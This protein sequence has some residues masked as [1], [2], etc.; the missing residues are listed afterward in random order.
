MAENP[1]IEKSDPTSRPEA[2]G[3]ASQRLLAL[4]HGF[5]FAKRCAGASN[6]EQLHLLLTNDITA[7]IEF[8]RAFLLSHVDEETRLVSVGNAPQVAEKTRFSEEATALGRA[9][10]G[11]DRGMLLPGRA[12]EATLAR[13]GLS[14][15]AVQGLRTYL[16]YSECDSLFVLPLTVGAKPIYHLVLEFFKG[17][18]PG[19]T[20]LLVLLSAAPLLASALGQKWI[21][22]RSPVVKELLEPDAIE[23]SRAATARRRRTWLG[24]ASVVLLGLALFPIPVR[25]GGEALI[26]T[27]TRHMA[28][29]QTGGLV[30]KVMVR[31]GEQVVQGQLLATIDPRELDHRIQSA[32]RQIQIY[33]SEMAFL[34]RAAAHGEVAKLAEKSLVELKRKQSEAELK[35]F[36]WQKGFLEIRAPVDGTVIT[37]DVQS[38]A[39]RKLAEGEPLC[40]LLEAGQLAVDVYVSEDRISRVAIG[41]TLDLHL[42]SDP[43]TAYRFRVE[44]IAPRA[45]AIPRL[46]N[47]FRVRTTFSGAPEQV[48]PGMKGIGRIEVARGS[49]GS[50]LLDRILV[51]WRKYT[52]AFG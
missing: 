39:G 28:F 22:H 6:L 7:L 11:I 45:E 4:A 52:L 20:R 16:A 50:I 23:R 2:S 18:N 15:A 31:E 14:P 49:L 25:V 1:A 33:S 24:V 51:T 12:D 21:L 30:E 29:C 37:R 47:V 8:D 44:E 19:E 27:K 13:N 5:E 10:R 34:E 36:Q 17:R 40:E 32:E 38:F 26:A 41:Q 42:D 9:L 43:R 48:K 46:G 35:Y 3:D